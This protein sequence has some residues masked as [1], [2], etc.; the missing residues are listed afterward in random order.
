ME[1]VL[2]GLRE[3]GARVLVEPSLDRAPFVMVLELPWTGERL[4]VVA[5]LFTATSRRTLNRP[6]DEAR[7]QIKYGSKA[8]QN[9]NTLFQDPNGLWT[10]VLWGI[11]VENGT[12]VAADPDVHNPTKFFISVEYKR[13][14]VDD[15]LSKGWFAWDRDRSA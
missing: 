3:A 8:D 10:T 2:A 5:Y 7:F 15:V 12:A 11:D 4:G 1:W 6:D 14:H 13:R 9:L